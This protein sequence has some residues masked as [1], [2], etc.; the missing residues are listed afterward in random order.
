MGKM[1]VHE[2]AKELKLSSKEFME[3]L[4][5]M[6]IEVKSH[7]SSL[8]EDEVEKIKKNLGKKS[9]K[10]SESKEVKKSAETESTAKKE[11]KPISPVIT[12]REVTRVETVPDDRKE[13][14]H[15]FQRNDIG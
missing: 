15:G 13:E 3:K 8:E 4:E 1:K 9:S 6:G 11:R 7:M 2:L 14:T 10:K 12:R 5:E